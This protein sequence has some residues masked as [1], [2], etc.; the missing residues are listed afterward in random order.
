MLKNLTILALAGAL[1]PACVLNAGPGTDSDSDTDSN[2]TS[3]TDPSNGTS[4]TDTGTTIE[5]VTDSSLGG[6][7]TDSGTDAATEPTTA[8]T[9]DQTS[10]TTVSTTEQ[11]SGTTEGTT[12]GGL[13]GDCGWFPKPDPNSDGDY[14]EC[15]Q[16]GGQ[17]GV[18]DPEGLAPIACPDGLAVDAKCDEEMGPVKNVGCCTPEG[19]LYF[20]DDQGAE[21]TNAVKMVDCSAP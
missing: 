9:T 19:I 18:E 1:L 2:A 7:G 12:G 15:A 21:A 16:N 4:G 5:P 10:T 8:P 11:T 17:S 13:Y 20:C 6:T 14:Y 3:G